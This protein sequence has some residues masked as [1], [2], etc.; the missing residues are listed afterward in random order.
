M[1]RP[2]AVVPLLALVAAGCSSGSTKTTASTPAPVATT[3]AASAPSPTPSVKALLQIAGFSYDPDPLT[4]KPGA[5]VPVTNID[6]VEHTVTSDTAGLFAV[7]VER[8]QV[9][10]FRAPV[11][12][13]TYTDH[14]A[15][16]PNMHGKLVVR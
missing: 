4:V 10:T 6:G 7:D 8:G 9:L 11:K 1:R 13:G 14:C 16:H 3:P 2:L 15:F 12:A 5:A